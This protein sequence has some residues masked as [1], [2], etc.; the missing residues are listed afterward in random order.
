M[1]LS[2]VACSHCHL[3][4]DESV[5]IVDGSEFFCCKGC[6]GIYHLLKDEGLGSFY[7][8]LGDEKLAPP[9]EQFEKSENFDAPAFYERYVHNK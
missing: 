5:M 2:K 8:K 7:N 9:T 1:T 4:F 3:E 6:Q